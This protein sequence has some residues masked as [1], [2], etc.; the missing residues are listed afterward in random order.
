[1]AAHGEDHQRGRYPRWPGSSMS[2]TTAA[3]PS[4]SWSM[5]P[6]S[7]SWSRWLA[8]RSRGTAEGSSSWPGTTRCRPAC[9]AEAPPTGGP[10]LSTTNTKKRNTTAK[11]YESEGVLSADDLDPITFCEECAPASRRPGPAAQL[12]PGGGE[13][14]R[15][16]LL[17]GDPGPWRNRMSGSPPHAP[18]AAHLRSRVW[19]P[20]CRPAPA[21]S[22]RRRQ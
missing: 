11:L 7:G 6:S 4:W 3:P 1:M 21:L 10:P 5:W 9:A 12:A 16:C 22:S 2:T 19:T 13:L 18:E 20:V 8:H 15:Q 17:V 14:L